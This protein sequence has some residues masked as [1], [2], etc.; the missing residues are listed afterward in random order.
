MLAILLMSP[1]G[2]VIGFGFLGAQ[3]GDFWFSTVVWLHILGSSL[4]GSNAV[5]V[6]EK[7]GD[8]I[9]KAVSGKRAV[10]KSFFIVY[11]IAFINT[12]TI[13]NALREITRPIIEYK[14]MSLA[15]PILSGSPC[16]ITYL[17]PP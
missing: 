8:R 12:F 10:S 14:I 9:R 16:D 15:L 13:P 17:N 11:V 7:T 5:P 2:P 3:T 4:K 6:T 1:L